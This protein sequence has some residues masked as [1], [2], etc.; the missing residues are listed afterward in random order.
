MATPVSQDVET[1]EPNAAT[2][3]TGT[4]RTNQLARA[5]PIGGIYW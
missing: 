5:T 2:C 4:K 1:R 3:N